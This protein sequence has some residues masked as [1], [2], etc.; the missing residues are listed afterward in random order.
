METMD[1]ALKIVS[2]ASRMDCIDEHVLQKRLQQ[3]P[4]HSV[5]L[6]DIESKPLCELYPDDAIRGHSVFKGFD[7]SVKRSYFGFFAKYAKHNVDTTYY[8]L[9]I[10]NDTDVENLYC[11]NVEEPWKYLKKVS[12]G[13]VFIRDLLADLLLGYEKDG[14]SFWDNDNRSHPICD[15]SKMSPRIHSGL[16]YL[17]VSIPMVIAAAVLLLLSK[18][19][20][21]EIVVIVNSCVFAIAVGGLYLMSSCDNKRFVSKMCQGFAGG[22]GLVFVG[23]VLVGWYRSQD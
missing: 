21:I 9:F 3:I 23:L 19:N 12:F 11:C 1:N 20:D 14:W 8:F 16:F 13:E 17:A 18:H 6:S 7:A 2:R 15:S 4:S 22:S 5:P 10:L